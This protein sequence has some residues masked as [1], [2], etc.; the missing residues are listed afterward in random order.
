MKTLTGFLIGAVAALCACGESEDGGKIEVATATATF[1][2]MNG[3]NVVGTAKF[4]RDPRGE[5]TLAVT[6]TAA[7]AGTHGIHI[8]EVP[9]CG[10]QGMDAG[11]HWDDLDTGPANHHL[12]PRDS[13]GDRAG[14]LGDLG[15][16]EVAT[17]GTGSLAFSNPAWTLGDG[18]ATDVVPHAIILHQMVDDGT[19]PSAGA[20][21][22]CALIAA[23]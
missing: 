15:N 13:G 9:S 18:A 7:P 5:V 19:M 4:T 17:D 11:P 20:R 22:G 16:I 1:A 10:N 14:H 2:G 21:W 12:P 3:Q 8:H 23:D 6:L